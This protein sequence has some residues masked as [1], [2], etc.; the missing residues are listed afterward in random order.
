LKSQ[1]PRAVV[2]KSLKHTIVQ[3][4]K[5]N[6]NGDFVLTSATSQELRKLGWTGDTS[7]LPAAYLTGLLAG[8]RAIAKNIESAV[9]DIGLYPPI[10][11]SRIFASLQGMVDAGITVPHGEGI[12]P[13]KDRLKGTHVSENK[14]KEFEKIKNRII[15]DF[16]KVKKKNE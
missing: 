6:S 4:I 12:L 3:F 11:G 8:K 1:Q 14:I 9:L 13:D 15:E 10:K 7:N 16:N 2:R 5:Y